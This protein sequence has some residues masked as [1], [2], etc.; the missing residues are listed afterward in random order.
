MSRFSI[1]TPGVA[2]HLV[3]GYAVRFTRFLAD[4]FDTLFAGAGLGGPRRKL[5]ASKVASVQGP[6]FVPVRVVESS[7]RRGS[8]GRVLEIVLAVR[9]RDLF[10]GH[11][12]VVERMA[13][14]DPA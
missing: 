7:A 6:R 10:A 5:G 1:T 8:V 3:V 14:R 13:D 12:E 9:L 4:G 11:L 2:L